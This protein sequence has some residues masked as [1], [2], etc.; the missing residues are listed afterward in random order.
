MCRLLGVSK[1][2]YYAWQKRLPSER[3]RTDE[4]LLDHIVTIHRESR[5][6]YGAPRVQADLRSK[7]QIRCS[8]RRV[9][10]LMRQAGLA[11]VKRGKKRQLTKRDASKTASPD[12]VERRFT[13][14]APDR[15]WVADI[16]QHATAEGWLYLAVVIDL[17]S[18]KVIGWAM[19]ERLYAELVVNALDMALKN[20]RPAPGLIHHSDHGSQYTSFAFGKRLQQAGILGSMGSVG[21]ALDNAAAESFFS[22]LQVELLE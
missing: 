19:S 13:A 4:E 1:S 2:G 10:R 20:R 5:G 3:T 8:K 15:L 16:T 18:R 11:G 7:Y 9:A 17:F 14:V 22:T 6:L 21:D 12:L